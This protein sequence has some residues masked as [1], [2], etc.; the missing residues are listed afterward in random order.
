MPTETFTPDNLIAG[1]TQL[2]TDSVTIA[3]SIALSR[4]AV[5]GI[6]TASGKYLL[7]ANA[8]ADGTEV[9]TAIL[10]EDVD[11]SG[12]DVLNAVIY[13]KGEFNEN[14]LSFGTASTVATTKADLR[15]VGIFIKSAVKA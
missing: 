11:A 12:G 7:S 3:S 2:V 15:K 6:D 1:T 5:L 13:I 10:A 14:E 8:A 9:A 4:G